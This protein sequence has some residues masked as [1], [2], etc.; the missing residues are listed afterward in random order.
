MKNLGFSRSCRS[1][2]TRHD[3]NLAML[4]RVCTLTLTAIL[5]PAAVAQSPVPLAEV[6]R[7]SYLNA[8]KQEQLENQRKMQAWF[9]YRVARWITVVDHHPVGSLV[10]NGKL[11]ALRDWSQ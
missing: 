3:L 5:T 7:I 9:I 4:V 11:Q 2:I 1:T 8:P 10:H 6:E